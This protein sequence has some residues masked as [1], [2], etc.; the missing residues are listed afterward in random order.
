MHGKRAWGIFK[1]FKMKLVLVK[2]QDRTPKVGFRAGGD[3]GQLPPV[4][5]VPWVP[6]RAP[7]GVP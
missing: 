1:L 3:R 5:P 6:F 2:Q 7:R 4:L